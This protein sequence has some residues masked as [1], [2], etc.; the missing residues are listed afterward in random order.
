MF[1]TNPRYDSGQYAAM[2]VL[3]Q[4]IQRKWNIAL[5]DLWNDAAFN[6]ITTEQR[7]R[8]MA[9]SIH[10][11][12]EGYLEWWTPYLKRIIITIIS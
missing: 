2:V 4:N 7:S 5:I 11:T 3:L 10:P 8:Y 1:Y 9:D 12:R 6:D